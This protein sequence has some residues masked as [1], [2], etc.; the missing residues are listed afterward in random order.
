MESGDIL[1][2]KIPVSVIIVTRNRPQLIQQCLDHL[3]RQD[4]EPFE[5]IVVDA[6][7]DQQTEEIV[8][9]YPTVRYIYLPNGKN[10]MT[11]SRNLGIAAAKG[12]I[13]AFIDDDSM[14]REG[15]LANLVSSY[16]AEDI[17]GVGGRVIDEMEIRYQ[18]TAPVVGRVLPDGRL[19]DNFALEVNET[20][21]VDR[22]KGCNMS[23]RK[24]VF[25]RVGLFD[26]QYDA[27]PHSTFEEVDFCTR[28]KKHGYKLL[29][30]SQ[31]VVDHLSA[32]RE[33]GLPRSVT[34]DPRAMFSYYHNRTYF[35]LVNFGW[36]GGHL[37]S[38]FF[39]DTTGYV[40]W[41]FEN[42]SVH[43]LKCLVANVWGKIIGAAAALQKQLAERKR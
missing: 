17:G 26:N 42:P 9:Q 13:I 38:L 11:Q 2:E 1:E 4:Y 12:E 3:L 37:A 27:T 16:N 30:N 23:F 35:V 7:S 31:A 40:Y 28:V 43:G 10:K 41:F 19:I 25:Q 29:F 22:L 34:D 14:V 8:K 33:D 32:P 18:L 15:W 5:M 21:K 20:I 39:H 36:R 6:S 24:Q